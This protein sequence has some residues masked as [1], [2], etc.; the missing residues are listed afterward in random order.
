MEDLNSTVSVEPIVHEVIAPHF[1]AAIGG[2]TDRR[3][4][5]STPFVNIP[6]WVS[7]QM[8][9][10]RYAHGWRLPGAGLVFVLSILF[11]AGCLCQRAWCSPRCSSAKLAVALFAN[12]VVLP[13][14][15]LCV[16][17][18]AASAGGPA[19]CYARFG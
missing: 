18:G 19:D 10:S 9:S 17:A 8:R 6:E 5:T 11:T 15:L 12:F 2:P 3:P 16:A 4:E 13:A 1:G 14:A 7:P